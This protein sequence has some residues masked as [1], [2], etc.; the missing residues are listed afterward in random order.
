MM[1]AVVPGHLRGLLLGVLLHIRVVL[2]GSLQIPRLQVLPQLRQSLQHRIR[3]SRAAVRQV[4]R[5]RGVILLRLRQV[6]GLQVL[7][8]LLKLRLEL[9]EIRRGSSGALRILSALRILGCA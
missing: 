9:L 4:L 1:A 3:G 7:P 8:K 2:L 5:Q 6:A